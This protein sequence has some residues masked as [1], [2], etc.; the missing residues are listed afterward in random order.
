[1]PLEEST[2]HP[3]MIPKYSE[4]K[5]TLGGIAHVITRGRH[6]GRW[7]D[8]SNTDEV[9]I[10]CSEPP[11]TIGCM[12]IESEYTTGNKELSIIL[13]EHNNSAVDFIEEEY[14]VVE[15]GQ[16]YESCV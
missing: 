13:V 7:P 2:C 4:V 14:V 11:N 10:N 12:K 16:D 8:F 9:C 3:L 6:V 5:K 15:D 1:M